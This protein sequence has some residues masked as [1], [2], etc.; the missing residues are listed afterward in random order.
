MEGAP[1]D[2]GYFIAP[3][4]APDAGTIAT[5][6]YT[7]GTT[8]LPKGARLPHAYWMLRGAV[9]NAQ[10]YFPIRRNLVAQPFHYVD[11]Q[12]MFMLA[13][14]GGGTA[15]V[16]RR[17]SATR[18]LS[19]VREHRVNFCSMPEV[20]ARNPESPED[21]RTDLKV[22]YSYS[23]HPSNYRGYERRFGC[24][25]RQGFGMTELGSSLHVPVEA[26]MMTGTGTVGIPS[27]HRQ[28]RI[29]DDAGCEPP[30]GQV[31][32]IVV[33]GFAMFA[34]YHNRAEANDTAFLPGG[35][36]RTGDAGRQDSDG[37][38]HYLGRR[39]DMIRR[40][41]ENVSAVEVEAVL[42][43]VPGIVEAAVAAV[44]D[45]VREE[46]IKAYLRLDED[47]TPEQV[48]PEIV[49]AHCTR[50]LAR[51]KIPRCIEYVADFPRTPSMKVRKAEL[52]ARKPDLRA[53]AYDR[54]DGI[55]RT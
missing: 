49:L 41:G 9:W 35:W 4:C 46:A 12:A 7:S 39:K 15:Y 43:G 19:W 16:A 8:G 44:P 30:R 26:D 17:Q 28:V 42:R 37:F 32:E 25:V 40:S 36:F 55:W 54:V 33:R 47:V 34:G 48:T 20:V 13:L 24:P 21:A 45:A 51:F 11:G 3:V 10:L 38:F 14:A 52:I 1:Y 18:F 31:G 27:A 29:V 5:I 23:H 22:I 6:Q 53:G 2:E 50:N